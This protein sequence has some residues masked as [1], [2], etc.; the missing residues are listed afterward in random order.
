MARRGACVLIEQLRLPG[1]SEEGGRAVKEVGVGA[2]WRAPIGDEELD[3]KDLDN[4]G[5]HLN[6]G[7]MPKYTIK[8]WR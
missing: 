7:G 6:F 8:N 4:H 2:R 1:F 5:R 3:Q